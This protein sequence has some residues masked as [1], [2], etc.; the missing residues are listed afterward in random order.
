[1]AVRQPPYAK[2]DIL[3]FSHHEVGSQ[4]LSIVAMSLDLFLSAIGTYLD[5][6]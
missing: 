2:F 5:G 4:L 3:I 6:V 1:M